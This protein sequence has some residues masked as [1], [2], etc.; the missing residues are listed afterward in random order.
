[1]NRLT[2]TVMSL[3]ALP[4]CSI[5]A[6]DTLPPFADIEKAT[7]TFAN[8]V[9]QGA[10][11]SAGRQGTVEELASEVVARCGEA[12]SA[13]LDAKSVPVMFQTVEEFDRVHLH[14][15]RHEITESR[16]NVR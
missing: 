14:V 11:Q 16:R 12:R 4:A 6:S 9:Y 15:A 2:V 10:K 5:R 13:A 3:F 7:L 8:C 1:M